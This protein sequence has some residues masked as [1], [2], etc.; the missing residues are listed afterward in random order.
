MKRR[1]WYARVTVNCNDSNY[2]RWIPTGYTDKQAA[3]EYME[4]YPG[5]RYV[6][7]WLLL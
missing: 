5:D 4:T 1:Y 3:I 2:G 7:E 6:R